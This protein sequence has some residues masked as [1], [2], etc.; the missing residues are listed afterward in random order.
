MRAIAA[1][2]ILSGGAIAQPDARPEFEVASIKPAEPGLAW[3]RGGWFRT[4]PGGRANI[5]NLTL[6]EL[7][8][9]RMAHSGTPDF[10]RT[11]VAR[12]HA[13]RYNRET[14]E[15]REMGRNP[16]DAPITPGG[17]IPELHRE[18]K[19]LPIY[20]LVLAKKDG[21]LGPGLVESKE[22]GCTPR[23]PSRP[24]PQPEP[25]KLPTPLCGN[26][27][28]NPRFVRAARLPFA[29]LAEKLS[30][31]LGRTVVDKTS[32]PGNFDFSLEW[33]PDEGQAMQLPPGVPQPRPSDSAPVS[34]FTA[35]QEQLGLKIESQKGPVEILV[36]TRAEKPSEN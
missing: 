20:A 21:K 12:F 35:L 7:I 6:K 29:S 17:P 22:G 33:T 23:D 9:Q 36:I 30:Q 24:F 26:I 1:V 11:R 19:E 2:L 16:G 14:R 15:Q 25:G 10:G 31:V 8:A 28:V 13:L 3:L 27:M 32:L 34:I 4:T 5:T 18:T